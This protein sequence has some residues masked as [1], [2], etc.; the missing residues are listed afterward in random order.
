MIT[1]Y[2]AEYVDSMREAFLIKFS[3]DKRPFAEKLK[4]IYMPKG[5]YS[6]LVNGAPVSKRTLEVMRAHLEARK[7]K[8]VDLEDSLSYCGSCERVVPK[9]EIRNKWTCLKCHNE[10]NL[11]SKHKFWGLHLE[12]GRHYKKKFLV[13]GPFR[14]SYLERR[15]RTNANRKYGRFGPVIELINKLKKEVKKYETE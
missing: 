14:D 7:P 10:I 12:V 4:D 1:S 6:A 5:T 2:S 11:K 3:E 13:R 9:A 8:F 15:R